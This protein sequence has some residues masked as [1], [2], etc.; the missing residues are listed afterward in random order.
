MVGRNTIRG[1]VNVLLANQELDAQR[2]RER[3]RCLVSF[4]VSVCSLVPQGVTKE[5]GG[6]KL[7]R[8]KN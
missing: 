3:L 1:I 5:G 6:P 4:V 2:L 8:E 7:E